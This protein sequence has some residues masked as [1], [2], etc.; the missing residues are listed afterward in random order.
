MSNKDT[1][2]KYFVGNFVRH[3]KD[4]WIGIIHASNINYGGQEYVYCIARFDEP[5]DCFTARMYFESEVDELFDII[6]YPWQEFFK[7]GDKVKVDGVKETFT[8]CNIVPSDDAPVK[9][10]N[11]GGWMGADTPHELI[12]VGEA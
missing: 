2:Q 5:V 6:P 9:I 10:E 8:I 4:N 1:E 7:V 11:E 3:K 12:K